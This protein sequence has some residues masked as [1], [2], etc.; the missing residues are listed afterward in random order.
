[1]PLLV[2]LLVPLS[3]ITLKYTAKVLGRII[4]GGG[5]EWKNNT[6]K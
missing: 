4:S 6:K 3:V 5:R 2:S 1:M